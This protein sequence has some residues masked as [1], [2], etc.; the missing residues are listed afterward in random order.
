MATT[1]IDLFDY[2][3]GIHNLVVLVFDKA[4]NQSQAQVSFEIMANI[5]STISDIKEIYERGWLTDKSY[6]ALFKKAL[7][8]LKLEAKYF[9]RE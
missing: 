3:L 7:K 9:D 6:Q 5:D 4:G 8:L 1:T 2:L